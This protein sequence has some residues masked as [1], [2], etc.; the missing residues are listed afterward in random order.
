MGSFNM[1]KVFSVTYVVVMHACMHE[2]RYVPL[3][4]TSM[5]VPLMMTRQ[6]RVHYSINSTVQCL[7]KGYNCTNVP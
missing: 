5:Q 2:Y 4:G 6:G 7:K 1:R 3:K